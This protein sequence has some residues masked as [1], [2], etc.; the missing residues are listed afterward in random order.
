MKV[1]NLAIIGLGQLGGSLLYAL[2]KNNFTENILVSSQNP[3][4]LKII[5]EKKL[6]TIGP[7]E[8]I[9]PQ[10]D[11]IILATSIEK[12]KSFLVD[13]TEFIKENAV[14]TDVSSVM[15][16]IKS[17]VNKLE[18]KYNWTFI[19]SHPMAGTEKTGFE[20]ASK[21]NLYKGKKV[22]IC[23]SNNKKANEIVKALW[24]SLKSEIIEISP[25]EHDK[26]LAFSSH[27]LHLLSAIITKINLEKS[28]KSQKAACAG[29]FRDF[30]R[31]SS[32]SPNMWK[33]IIKNNQKNIIKSIDY[34]NEEL[35]SFKK[36]LIEQDYEKI[37]EYLKKA[38]ILHK[39]WLSKKFKKK[40]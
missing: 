17:V 11:L 4:T 12:V 39:E 21:K 8:A 33:E 27:I 34:L 15:E 26:I 13:N 14:I 10:A 28:D 40:I 29:A 5:K 30:S 36:T 22:F 2:N 24:T 3:Q 38:N 35:I 20:N 25:Q 9:I 18:K 16:E 23:P 32:S 7:L 37:E 6:A 1:S 31:I 19:A